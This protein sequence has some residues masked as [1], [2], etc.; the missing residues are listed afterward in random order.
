MKLYVVTY[1]TESGDRGVEGVFN[2]KPDDGHLATLT[3]INH[4]DEIEDE[5]TDDE[6]RLI[7]YDIQEVEVQDLPEPS[8][9]IPSI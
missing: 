7:F 5:D 1:H 2:A 8:K 3:R 9:P 6:R 4:P